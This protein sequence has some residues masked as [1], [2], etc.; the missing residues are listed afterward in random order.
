MQLL[1]TCKFNRIKEHQAPGKAPEIRHQTRHLTSDQGARQVQY[2]QTNQA[3]P[4]GVL[5]AARGSG[6]AADTHPN[7]GHRRVNKKWGQTTVAAQKQ[8]PE[9]RK[10][11]RS[12]ASCELHGFKH[13]PGPQGTDQQPTTHSLP[14]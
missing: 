9:M 11:H 13:A 10:H 3:E 12:I 14:V 8:T 4:A 1:A 5:T 7:R 2:G 6:L